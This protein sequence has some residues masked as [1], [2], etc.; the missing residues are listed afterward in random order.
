MHELVDNIITCDFDSIPL[1]ELP[2]NE[3]FGLVVERNGFKYELLIH[4]NESSDKLICLGSGALNGSDLER[5]KQ[6]PRFH[7]QS[8]KFDVST[9]FYNDP[10]RYLNDKMLGGWG[11]GNADEWCLETIK[12]IIMVIS[13]YIGYKH[14]NILFYGSSLGGFMSI[15][16]ATLVKDSTALADVPQL[17]FDYANY[18][19]RIKK[20]L[21]P[22]LSDEE[23]LENYKHRLN[24]LDLIKKEEYIPNAIMI[25]DAGEIDIN[26]H[27]LHFFRDLGKITNLNDNFMKIVINPIDKHKFLKMSDSLRVIDEACNKNL[28]IF[29]EEI[30]SSELYLSNQELNKKLDKLESENAEL[31]NKVKELES[32]NSKLNEE[33]F[34]FKNRKVD[35]DL[36]EFDDNK[37]INNLKEKN[38]NFELKLNKIKDLFGD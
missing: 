32:E 24:V 20:I 36:T 30:S 10:T 13:D 7:R 17:T 5:F 19:K 18:W 12:D 4:L 11:I 14:E 1:S 25:F 31:L 38:R 6:R 21:F 9:I 23:I 8:W 29:N 15:M 22:D 27:Y 28:M 35:V 34:N 3:R 26:Q 2:L 16:L 33:I 37:N